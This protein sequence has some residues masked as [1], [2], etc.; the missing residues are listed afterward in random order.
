[1]G[2]TLLS[3]SFIVSGNSIAIVIHIGEENYTSKISSGAKYVKKVNSEIMKSL[4]QIIRTISIVINPVGI[5]LFL[6]QINLA[7]II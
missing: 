1:M 2:D 7:D 6:N 3:G 5:L 4:N